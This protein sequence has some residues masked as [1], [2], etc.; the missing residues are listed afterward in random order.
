MNDNLAAQVKR[1]SRSMMNSHA[2][3]WA[4]IREI[5]RSEMYKY[6]ARRHA[7]WSMVG[8]PS[9]SWNILS[10]RPHRN[11]RARDSICHVH[12]GAD[13][14]SCL[15]NVLQQQHMCSKRGGVNQD[16]LYIS[17]RQSSSLA[18]RNSRSCQGPRRE[19]QGSREMGSGRRSEEDM[20]GEWERMSQR[21]GHKYR[22]HWPRRMKGPSAWRDSARLCSISVLS[23]SVSRPK[24]P[25]PPLHSVANPTTMSPRILDNALGGV[26]HTPL[27]RLDKIAQ[28]NGLKCN[29]RKQ[30]YSR[31]VFVKI[32]SSPFFQL[33]R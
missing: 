17:G 3:L 2:I 20:Y 5:D 32:Y 24:P 16:W 25:P 23:R 12:T 31:V 29:L 33:E 7:V 19:F 22:R 18:P 13:D 26:G 1:G 27:I 11:Q 30:I 6:T 14:G 8:A 15:S 9:Q 10:N 21:T 4:M 28:A